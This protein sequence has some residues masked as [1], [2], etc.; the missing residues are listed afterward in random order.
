MFA[1]FTVKR[2]ISRPLQIARCTIYQQNGQHAEKL[3]PTSSTIK[4]AVLRD[5]CQLRA[6]VLSDVS[7]QTLWMT[8]S[9]GG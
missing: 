7:I 1:S 6:L 9:T 3:Q 8:L 2:K 5:H 4:Q